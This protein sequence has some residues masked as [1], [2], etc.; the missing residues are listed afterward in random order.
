MKKKW[1][2]QADLSLKQTQEL[3]TYTP[4]VQKLLAHRGIERAK[5]AEVFLRP[6]YERDLLDPFLMKDMAKAV[7]RLLEAIENK[8]RV[9]IFGDYDA[10]GVPGATM[11][12]L[13]FNKM[14]YENYE[15]YI[16]DRH[17]E[18][19]GLNLKAVTEF[20]GREVKLII[21]IDCGIRDVAE[22][23]LAAEHGLD[24]II[25]DHHLPGEIL[26]PAYAIV[27]A[28]Q[29]DDK[30][31]EKML[32]GAGVMFKFIGAVLAKNRF[33]IETG[34]EKWL[35]D[36]AAI[37]TVSDMVPLVGENRLLAY[38]GL[39]VLRQ[40]RR[41]GLLALFNLMKIKPVN[42]TED[43][44]GFMI[45]PR[46][47]S[48]SRMSHA[49]QAYYLLTT[50]DEAEAVTI[51]KHLEEKNQ[52]RRELTEK[53]LT[54]ISALMDEKNLP[55]IIVAG[56]AD[57]GLGILG[58]SC[59]RL[60]EK[61]NRPVWLWSK[62]EAGT[63]K[64]SCRSDGTINLVEVMTLVN[65]TAMAE[66]GKDFFLNAGGH[67]MAAGFSLAP[68]REAE[69]AP[70]LLAAY[71][72]APKQVTEQE[73]LVDAKLELTDLT[74]DT[75]AQIEQLAPFGV[76]NPKPVFWLSGAEITAAKSFGNGGLHLELTF[77]KNEREKISAIGFFQCLA[78]EIFNGPNGHQFHGVNLTPGE[79]VDALVTL[80][81]ST[82]KNYP[83]L[84]LR[85][86]DLKST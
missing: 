3:K 38:Y 73:F 24:V 35:L 47:N 23:R 50:E 56:S 82:F 84:R 45:G 22:V 32:A 31:P 27:N 36:L 12:A 1:K 54:A 30:Y 83:E 28:K 71:A 44:I 61:Y 80:E 20:A 10:D 6:D 5:L 68:E 63:I 58:L 55:P 40:T 67:A 33:G 17:N 53:V 74:W 59:S 39:K 8:E 48:A 26:P 62:N 75:Y 42:A 18:D 9:V 81:K 64:G 25:T 70:R 76:D 37:A 34:W 72:Q 15:V 78:G 11:L 49:S 60:V 52:S 4:L 65:Q 16:P 86:V 77:K 19:Y 79:R 2:L 29:S 21:T 85:I 41:P 14:G 69:L 51:A 46:I 13:L 66:T 57:W 7:A 43:D